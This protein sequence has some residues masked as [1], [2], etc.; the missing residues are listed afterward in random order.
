MRKG[1]NEL[2]QVLWKCR[3]GTRELD[4]ILSGFAESHYQILSEEGKTEFRSLLEYED[5][6]LI[7][8]LCHQTKPDIQGIEKIVSRIW[9]AVGRRQTRSLD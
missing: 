1:Q 9:S 7:G 5:P 6:L 2:K 4:L 3:R 8:W